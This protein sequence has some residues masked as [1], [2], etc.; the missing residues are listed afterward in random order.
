MQSAR[1]ATFKSLSQY[2]Y[3][4]CY[5]LY[6][7]C[8]VAVTVTLT[9]TVT[10]TVIVTVTVAVAVTVTV[11][12]NCYCCYYWYGTYSKGE[13]KG[14]GGPGGSLHQTTTTYTNR[15]RPLTAGF[16]NQNRKAR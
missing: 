13:R 14:A 10:V 15:S 5:V 4:L 9:V 3:I 12:V 1:E 6:S 7:I 2:C 8:A 11:T 16:R